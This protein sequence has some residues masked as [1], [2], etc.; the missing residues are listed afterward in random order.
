[1]LTNVNMKGKQTNKNQTKDTKNPNKN[2]NPTNQTKPAN[3]SEGLAVKWN[4]SGFGMPIVCKDINIFFCSKFWNILPKMFR[5][6]W[7]DWSHFSPTGVFGPMWSEGF[8]CRW[9]CCSWD[10][11]CVSMQ[12]LLVL[13]SR[14]CFET[15]PLG[16][17]AHPVESQ[18]AWS[19]WNGSFLSLLFAWAQGGRS[20]VPGAVCPISTAG[21]PGRVSGDPPQFLVSYW[22]QNERWTSQ[23]YLS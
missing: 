16:S 15:A 8:F 10:S 9:A 4:L 3:R 12:C 13:S 20:R 18:L 6:F 23:E 19:R 2:K 1:M 7:H 17:L 11:R 14:R 22:L 21:W 5:L